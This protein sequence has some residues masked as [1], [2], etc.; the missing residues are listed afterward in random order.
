MEKIIVDVCIIG[1]GS[2]GIGAAY[3]FVGT[4]TSVLLVEK[5]EQLGGTPV[6]ANVNRWERGPEAPF[7]EALYNKLKANGY[8]YIEGGETDYNKT[9]TPEGKGV[10][11]NKAKYSEYIEEDLVKGGIA[12]RKGVSFVEA[13]VNDKSTKVQ[14]IAIKA[15]SEMIYVEAKIYIDATQGAVLCTSINSAK[16]TEV[17]QAGYFLGADAKG[18]FNENNAPDQHQDELNAIDYCFE[19]I[20]GNDTPCVKQTENPWGMSYEEPN[21]FINDEQVRIVNA[22]GML[23]LEGMKYYNGGYSEESIQQVANDYMEKLR[24]YEQSEGVKSQYEEYH[25][26]KFPK[27]VG[28]RESKRVSC[29]KMLTQCDI[30]KDINSVGY[31]NDFIAKASH[32]VDIHGNKYVNEVSKIIVPNSGYGI[33]YGVIVPIGLENVYV[34]SMSAGYSHIAAASVRLTRTLMQLGYAAAKASIILLTDS[35]K[36]TSNIDVQTLKKSIDANYN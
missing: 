7:C 30:I 27:W 22:C 12:V 13:T 16:I 4:G 19:I 21:Y 11:F 6:Y 20:K 1:G 28:V 8:A 26:E 32:P 24:G 36:N 5:E 18:T 23:S 3:G 14:K 34:V 35:S 33:P 15:N 31:E 2:S 29:Q 17:G 10:V 25:I 9:L